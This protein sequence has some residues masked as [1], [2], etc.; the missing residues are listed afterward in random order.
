MFINENARYSITEIMPLIEEYINAGTDVRIH[1]SGISLTP[2]LHDRRDTVVLSVPQNIK[3]YDI[4]LHKRANGQYILH[5]IIKKKGNTLTI[6]GDFETEKE[7]P[8]YTDAVIAKVTAFV[9]NGKSYTPDDFV[10]KLYSFLWVLI[11]PFRHKVLYLLNV[12]RGNID[13]KTKE[14]HN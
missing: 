1:V 5:R 10:I 3:K 4:V 9:R 6:A 14:K 12:L 2:I 11:F 13:V 8:V 7:Y